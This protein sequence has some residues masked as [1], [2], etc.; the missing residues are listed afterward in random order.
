[1]YKVDERIFAELSRDPTYPCAK[2]K[3]R[4][5]PQRCTRQCLQ[6]EKWIMRD[7]LTMQYNAGIMTKEEFD[8]R[9]ERVD[10]RC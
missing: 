5:N 8:E 4:E 9:M 2:C 3:S 7:W 1:M 10:E 6:W